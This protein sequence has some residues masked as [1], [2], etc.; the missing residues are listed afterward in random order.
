[1]VEWT[2]A[3]DETN[4]WV[5][6]QRKVK[7]LQNSVWTCRKLSLQV[8]SGCFFK[9]RFMELKIHAC[10]NTCILIIQRLHLF[11]L[12]LLSE[13]TLDACKNLHALKITNPS[14]ECK[15]T[16]KWSEYQTF[17]EVHLCNVEKIICAPIIFYKKWDFI[18]IRGFSR[19]ISF[20]WC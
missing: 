15:L 19:Q 11:A 4:C 5:I 2:G 13:T 10:W 20:N 1:M 18:C 6:S 8:Q 9:K 17:M 16:W 7:V 12:W 3:D 14:I